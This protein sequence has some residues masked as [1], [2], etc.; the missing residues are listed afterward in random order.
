MPLL[1]LGPAPPA[2]GGEPR[3][4][5]PEARPEPRGPGDPGRAAA[6]APVGDAPGSR[7]GTRT[8]DQFDGA[9]F[10]GALSIMVYYIRHFLILYSVNKTLFDTV[11]GQ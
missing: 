9:P 3:R 4:E 5:A 10:N 6:G 1:P 11:Y 8:R 2:G 7:A